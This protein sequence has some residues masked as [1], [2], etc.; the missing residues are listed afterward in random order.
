[1]ADMNEEEKRQFV[2][3]LQAA[4]ERMRP[5]LEDISKMVAEEGFHSGAIVHVL[6]DVAAEAAVIQGCP[7]EAAYIRHAKRAWR[8]ALEDAKSAPN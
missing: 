7:D 8:R 1:M 6:S 4:R 5:F 3:Q 2:A